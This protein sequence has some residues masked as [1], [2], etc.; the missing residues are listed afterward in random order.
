MFTK[1]SSGILTK[2]QGD[3]G[4]KNPFHVDYIPLVNLLNKPKNRLERAGIKGGKQSK[5]K[6]NRKKKTGRK[7][8]KQGRETRRR[9]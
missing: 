6:S 5:R 7:N 8:K 1:S 2:V 3:T 4:N 9:N